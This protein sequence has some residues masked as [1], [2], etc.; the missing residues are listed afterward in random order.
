[1]S[2]EEFIKEQI[3]ERINAIKVMS[4]PL[5]INGIDII[6][7]LDRLQL[8]SGIDKLAKIFDKQVEIVTDSNGADYNVV[9]KQITVDGVIIEECQYVR[10]IG[11]GLESGDKDV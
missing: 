9:T 4:I 7:S 6:E 2:I 5:K 11:K 1:M 10:K 3:T 8:Y